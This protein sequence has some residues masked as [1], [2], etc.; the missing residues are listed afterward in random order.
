MDNA[1]QLGEVKVSKLLLKFSIPAIVGML[2]NSIYN[3]VDRI[4]IGNGVGSLGIGGI[5][6]GFPVMMINMAISMLIG[7]GAN[8]VISIRLGQNRRDD[9][10]EILGNA[11]ILFIISAFAVTTL[12]LI[13]LEPLLR[14]FG[15]SDVLLPYAKDYMSIILMGNIFMTLSF[16]MN[17]FIRAE[18]NPKIAM[19]TMIIGAVTNIILD[20]IFIFVL[21]WGMKGAAFATILSQGVS[22]LWVLNYFFGGKSLLKIH[23]KNFRL[24]FE[25]VR[26]IAALGFAPFAM[27]LAN[28]VQNMIMNQSLMTYGGEIALSAMGVTMSIMTLIFMPM[29]GINQ[30]SQPIIG[31]NYGAKKYDRVKETLKLAIIASVSIALFGWI[32]TR[33]WPGQLIAVFNRSDAELLEIGKMQMRIG[34]SVFPLI[35]FQI[36][37]ANYF[38][39]VGKP[40]HASFLS[41]SRQFFFLIPLLLIMPRFFGLAGVYAAMPVSDILAVTVTGIFLYHEIR[42]LDDSHA[43]T[44]AQ[45]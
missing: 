19:K 35:G 42:H 23:T 18:G 28:S 32:I 8:A 41:L 14:I 22:M 3:I 45:R 30:G 37:G 2:V 17:N 5:T 39:A 34:L 20:P 21:G 6:V 1:T 33:L 4:Y 25:T 13:F 9:A 7:F 10:E 38:Q 31:Y 24:R 26:T 27:Q 11:F 43:S 12:G 15:A 36:V 40:R 44:V 29:I 16:G